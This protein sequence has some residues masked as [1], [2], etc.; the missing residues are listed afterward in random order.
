MD[1]SDFPGTTFL[2]LDPEARQG[3]DGRIPGTVSLTGYHCLFLDEQFLARNGP[4][5]IVYTTEGTPPDCTYTA[6]LNRMLDIQQ[7]GP[8]TA[9]GNTADSLYKSLNNLFGKTDA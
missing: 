8:T 3:F 7:F 6:A 9:L 2:E 1:P 4:L 5:Q